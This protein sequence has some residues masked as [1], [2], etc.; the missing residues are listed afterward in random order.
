M[1][2]RALILSVVS[3]VTH[4]CHVVTSYEYRNLS[5][6]S[7][8]LF[9][10]ASVVLLG[11]ILIN[12]TLNLLQRAQLSN[13]LIKRVK[14]VHWVLFAIVAILMVV[15]VIVSSISLAGIGYTVSGRDGLS[16]AYY[17]M[18]LITAI[19]A[20]VFMSLAASNMRKSRR[21]TKV[22]PSSIPYGITRLIFLIQGVKIW[23]PI[24]LASLVADALLTVVESFVFDLGNLR[25][26]L[27][28]SVAL[29]ALDWFLAIVCYL[30]VL[31]LAG[32]MDWPHIAFKSLPQSDVDAPKAFDPQQYVVQPQ[33][34][35][36]HQAPPQPPQ[37]LPNQPQQISTEDHKP[38]GYQQ[39]PQQQSWAYQPAPQQSP[40]PPQY[41]SANQ[42]PMGHTNPSL[43]ISNLSSAHGQPYQQFGT[44]R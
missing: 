25:V 8:V 14:V 23:V 34:Q 36:Y 10:I 43:P 38:W 26:D 42:V 40:Q 21:D 2:R 1:D 3:T 30:A 33:T 12:L 13:A 15:K 27:T 16:A 28:T 7:S 5:I 35:S 44:A 6:A 17:V 39:Q 22:C 19:S 31:K 11:I 41:W 9:N 24:L 18:Y 37:A 20:T 29:G 32:S 4:E